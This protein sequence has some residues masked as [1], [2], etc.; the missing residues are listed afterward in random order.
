MAPITRSQTASRRSY[1]PILT[2]PRELRETIWSLT[3]SYH[4]IQ[5]EFDQDDYDS[6]R[7]PRSEPRLCT[8]AILLV[9]HQIYAEAK[10]CLVRQGVSMTGLSRLQLFL[11]EFQIRESLWR[12]ITPATLRNIS[13][14]SVDLPGCGD[15][16]SRRNKN[17]GYPSSNLRCGHK[18]WFF[19]ILALCRN[20]ENVPAQ[21]MISN[22]AMKYT[23]RREHLTRLEHRAFAIMMDHIETAYQNHAGL[24][25]YNYSA[26]V[27]ALLLEIQRIEEEE[28]TEL[29]GKEDAKY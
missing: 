15:C 27:E 21:I 16:Q 13:R 7:V 28:N 10:A 23:L 9:N 3:A 24:R 14:F 11:K 20:S 2:L 19:L 5:K 6:Y 18:S 29:E 22:G 8:P 26:L 1:F 12:V 17:A 4:T 25:L